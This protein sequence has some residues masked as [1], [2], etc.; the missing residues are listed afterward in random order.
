M[1][2]RAREQS[3][4]AARALHCAAQVVAPRIG[5][6][7]N[8]VGV[9]FLHHQVAIVNVTGLIRLHPGAGFPDELPGDPPPHLAIIGEL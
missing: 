4:N 8:V 5:H 9:A 2:L 3:T 6:P 1:I 7:R